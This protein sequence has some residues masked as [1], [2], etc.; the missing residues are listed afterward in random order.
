MKFWRGFCFVVLHVKACENAQQIHRWPLKK[1]YLS[2]VVCSGC[3]CWKTFY[4]NTSWSGAFCYGVIC[5][6]ACYSSGDSLSFSHH[7]EFQAW[8]CIVPTVLEHENPPE[9][10]KFRQHN[11]MWTV[12][13]SG[14]LQKS[15]GLL[16][17]ITMLFPICFPVKCHTFTPKHKTA[18]CPDLGGRPGH[19]NLSDL[20]CL[21][22]VTPCMQSR[23]SLFPDRPAQERA[24]CC[25]GVTMGIWPTANQLCS[26]VPLACWNTTY[27]RP[28]IQP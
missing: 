14:A 21:L 9:Q 19:P 18:C 5:S 4:N 23:G 7:A 8:V 27:S 3:I 25:S 12:C 16:V 13:C 2:Q 24:S 1:R 26:S 20:F 15:S 10:N 22:H 17:L 28:C 11:C 6:T